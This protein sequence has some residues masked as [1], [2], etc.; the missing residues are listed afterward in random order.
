LAVESRLR[1]AVAGAGASP[2]KPANIKQPLPHNLHY[3]QFLRNIRSLA[4]ALF[5][6]DQIVANYIASYFPNTSAKVS[7]NMLL[8]SWKIVSIRSNALAVMRFTK[9]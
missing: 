2:L 6:H 3:C 7:T 4:L 1:N 9:L 8:E 5:H